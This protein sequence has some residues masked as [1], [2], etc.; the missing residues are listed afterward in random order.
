MKHANDQPELDLRAVANPG[1]I[2]INGRCTLKIEGSLRVVYVAGLPMHHWTDGDCATQAYAMV[3]LVRCGY[4]DQ[5]DVARSFG[6]S[7]RTLRRY[8]RCFET[9]G[10]SALGRPDGPPHGA[11]STPSPWV[12]TAK[13][14]RHAGV[15]VR[16]IAQRLG[17]SKSAVSKWLTR[18]NKPAPTNSMVDAVQDDGGDVVPAGSLDTDP[19]SR[20][21]DRIL[22]RLGKLDD[23]EPIF[24]PGRRIPRV[25]VLLAVPALTQSGIFSVADEVYGH[26]GPAFY[27][28]RT[29]MMAMLLMA[30]LRIKRPE[31]LKER[32]PVDLGRVL[33]L[34]RGP[35]VKTLRRKL[36]RL[37]AYGKAESFGRKLAQRRV[38]QHGRAMGFL[39]MD[40]HVRVYHGKHRLP[41]AHVTQMRMSLPAT[42]DC[43]VNDKNGDPLFV[44]TAEFNEGLV[45]MLP[46]LLK[47][48]RALI[49]PRRRVTVVF[50]R[51]GWSPK[52]FVKLIKARFDILTYRKGR[53]KDIPTTQ[54]VRCEKRIDGRQVSYDLNDRNI[55]LLKGRLRLRQITR[56]SADGHH[57]TAIVTS[58]WNL[59]AAVLA[60]R[61]FERWRQ[62]NFF[63][64]LGEEF[65]LDALADYKAESVDPER[66]VPNPQWRKVEKELATVRVELK[67]V[68]AQ[69]GQA[70]AANKEIRRPTI[71]GFK[72][73][74][75]KLGRRIR[76]IQGQLEVLKEKRRLIPKRVL[77][78]DVGGK[79]I[80]R[81]SRERHH[82]TNCIKMVAYQAESELLALLRPHYARA[83][84]EGRT[85]VTSA[86]ESA[87]SLEVGDS[88]LRVT[89]APLSSPHRSR[90]ITA[91][92]SALNG[93]NTRFPGTKL[94]LRFGVAS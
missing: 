44:V 82:L 62:E 57:Q 29:T 40:G 11:R 50:D 53:W 84:E 13:A 25:G 88:E 46:V 9:G 54:F 15:L 22:A 49:G 1:T 43:W 45:Q 65:A 47:E 74:H 5:N 70:A 89:L 86:F 75:G 68:Q 7:T 64:Y 87:G 51:G 3:S 90:A 18:L 2:P 58:R 52:L 32:A 77:A 91:L 41:K 42:T 6:C 24:T 48:I 4:A 93:M 35:E 94:K 81:L 80:M 17:V 36:T 31:G 37:A 8:Q 19:S 12:R 38:A 73:A 14:L 79:P 34:D 55:R 28:L 92:C 76:E 23:A 27:G 10:M 66:T 72:I 20:V 16:D 61:M 83:D 30:L 56:L 78:K 21:I 63:K 39:Y 85:L 67:K 69:Y 26:I 71:R 59:P 33:G 60:Y